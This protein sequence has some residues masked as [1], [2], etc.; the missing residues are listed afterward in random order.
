MTATE[1]H[2][3]KTRFAEFRFYEELNDF[4]PAERRKVSFR[5]PFFNTPAVRDVIQAIGVPHTAI[6]LV[7]VDGESVDFAH[8]LKGGERVAVYP[9]FERLDI[10]PVIRLRPEPLRETRFIAD[11][12]L[13]KLARYLRMLGFDSAYERRFENAEIIDRSLSEK[14]IIL[15]RSPELLKHNRVTHGYWVRHDD[16]LDQLLEVLRGLDLS[17][18][19]KPFTRC[20]DCN[21]GIVA[22]E[23]AAITGRIN[24]LILQRFSEFRQ[25][26]DCGKIYWKG[27]HN[28][29]M[30][31]MISR[32][33]LIMSDG[34]PT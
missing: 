24:P 16:P 11:A 5:W 2:P 20:M 17:R 1:S 25:C 15:T 18:Q 27:S 29:R 22:V 19:A 32:L 28:E 12:H 21:G 31:R 10:S 34:P 3:R 9:V 6:D 33:P 8:R 14:R 26:P 23:K 7:L 30:A 13:G 4:L